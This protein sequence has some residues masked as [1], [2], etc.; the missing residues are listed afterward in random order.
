M[1]WVEGLVPRGD[2]DNLSRPLCDLA[3]SRERR[4]AHSLI[5]SQRV[6]RGTLRSGGGTRGW[7]VGT[8]CLS[9]AAGTGG[10]ASSPGAAAADEDNSLSVCVV[11]V[12]GLALA[13][14]P[15]KSASS[16]GETQVSSAGGTGAACI[17]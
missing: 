13:C 9:S 14:A 11:V 17:R 6:M 3:T 10:A 8:T 7:L 2:G 15:A 4:P 5:L 1:I 16:K 12:L